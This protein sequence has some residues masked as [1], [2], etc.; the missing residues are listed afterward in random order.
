[1]IPIIELH[2]VEIFRGNYH[3][4]IPEV[5]EFYRSASGYIDE[6]IWSAAWMYKATGNQTY[7]DDA[8]RV[9][10]RAGGPYLTEQEYSWDQKM[11]GAQV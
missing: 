11:V 1:M 8:D 9:Y 4:S 7:L 5:G 6:L 3:E 10:R 2:S